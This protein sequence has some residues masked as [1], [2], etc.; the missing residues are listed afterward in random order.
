MY[1][2]ARTSLAL[3]F[4]MPMLA[5]AQ[6]AEVR[7]PGDRPHAPEDAFR[8]ADANRDGK[9][10]YEELRARRPNVSQDA[11]NRMDT[12]GDG[13]LTP[14]DRSGATQ[15]GAGRPDASKAGEARAQM[16]EKMMESDANGDGQVS[17][18]EISTSKPGFARQDFDRLDRD[19]DGTISRADLPRA[20][21]AGDRPRPLRAEGDAKAMRDGETREEFRQRLYASDANQDGKVTFGEAQASFPQLTQERFNAL[22]RNKDGSIGPDDRPKGSNPRGDAAPKPPAP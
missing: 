6:G 10:S 20:P 19:A 15:R 2:L 3:V 11:F 21:Q 8:R 13:S 1:G 14:A 17:F 5:W 9:V 7:A 4:L 16:L 18:D 22:D 12:D